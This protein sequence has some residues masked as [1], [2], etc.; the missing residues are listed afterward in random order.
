VHLVLH[1]GSG[2]P[3]AMMQG[4]IRM[5]GGGVSKVNIATDLE[6]A[7]LAALGRTERMSNSECAALP[8]DQ[9]RLAE[10]AVERTVIDKIEEYLGS[11]G[12][13]ADYAALVH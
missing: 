12:R 5:P 1:G 10:E 6:Q 4:A 11:G 2:V 9:L 3:P 13:A 8:A 7:L